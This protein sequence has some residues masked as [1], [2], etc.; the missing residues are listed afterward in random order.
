MTNSLKTMDENVSSEGAGNTE[1]REPLK[2]LEVTTGILYQNGRFFC[3]R[4]KPVNGNFRE[5]R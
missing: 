4:R 1:H 5:E 3:G 2:E